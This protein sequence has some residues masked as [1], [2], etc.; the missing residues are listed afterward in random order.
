MS[1]DKVHE[2]HDLQSSDAIKEL[3][4]EI[5]EQK[6]KLEYMQLYNK[7]LIELADVKRMI[8]VAGTVG[9]ILLAILGYLGWNT[10][11]KAKEA[12]SAQMTQAIH[13]NQEF[14]DNLMAG[15]ALVHQ[16]NLAAAIPKFQLCLKGDR[17]Y[18][19]S[20]LIPFLSAMNILDD[21]D[22]ALPILKDLE[23]DRR[24]FNAIDDPVVL[25]IIG[26]L[27]VQSGIADADTPSRSQSGIERMTEGFSLLQRVDAM[28]PP[29]DTD[30][31]TKALL[32][33]W[34][35]YIGK[36]QFK[37]SHQVIDTLSRIPLNKEDGLY[38]WSF[39]TTFACVKEIAKKDATLTG[40]V[41]GSK[42]ARD[43]VARNQ[44]CQ[45]KDKFLH[46]DKACAPSSAKSKDVSARG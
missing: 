22:D 5:Q 32:N 29:S 11:N 31:R 27:E 1:V 12:A 7:V 19:T 42:T 2:K 15:A 25:E 33:E 13:E 20:V 34:L 10:V 41:P 14:Y 37:E 38:N 30:T 40:A 43:V 6:L 21:W 23:S 4:A 36:G 46:D 3:R 17:K 44:W 9:T 8:Q 35:Y 26:A 45:L 16:G 28:L 39:L 18:D 24:K